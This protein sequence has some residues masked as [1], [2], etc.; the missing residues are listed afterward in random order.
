[1][2]A[3]QQKNS[4]FAKKKSF[5][6]SVTVGVNPTNVFLPSIFDVNLECL[7]DKNKCICD[8][9]AKLKSKKH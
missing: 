4:S 8:E 5:I 6:G 2:Q 7:Q 9:T 3:Y 1:M